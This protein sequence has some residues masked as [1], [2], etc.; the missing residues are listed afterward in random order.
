MMTAMTVKF[1]TAIC[2]DCKPKIALRIQQ[3]GTQVAIDEA[4]N[5]LLL[6]DACQN[7]VSSLIAKYSGI[8]K[9]LEEVGKDGTDKVKD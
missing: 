5:G 1:V 2:K 7:R 4:C 9:R 6:C 3:V 8:L